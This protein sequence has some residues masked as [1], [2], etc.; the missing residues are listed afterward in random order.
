METDF[1]LALAREEERVAK[2]TSFAILDTPDEQE[3]DTI[4]QLAQTMLG[5]PI[6]VVSLVDRHRQWFKAKCGLSDSETSRDVAFCAH[7]IHYDDIMVVEDATLD[8]R[9]VANPLVTGDPGIRF[10]AGAPLRP[11]SHGHADDLPA[12]GTLCVIDVKPRTFSEEQVQTLRKLAGLVSSLVHARASAATALKLSEET[13]RRADAIA[14][15]HVQ[16]RQAE[17][18]AG[19][20]SWRLDLNDRS[21]FWSD[22]VY[23]IHGLPT[24]QMPSVDQAL[25]FYPE[26]RRGEIAALVERARTHGESFDFESDF[27]TADGRKR[28]VRSMGEVQFIDGAPV[29]LIGVFQDVT[30]H[31]LR[32]LTLRHT[33]DTDALTGLPNRA[34]FERRLAE[35][36][37]RAQAA[38]EPA[39]VLLL[40]LD[41]FKGVNDTFGHDAGDE[42]LRLMADRLCELAYSSSFAARLGGDE[43]V[44]LVTRPRDCANIENVIASI[45]G[46][47]RHSVERDGERRKVSATVGAAFVEPD[48]DAPTEAMRRADLALYAA[49]RVER[50]TGRVF[51]SPKVLRALQARIA[52]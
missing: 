4:V 8:S 17:R 42:V 32:E 2:L 12:I 41:G 15:Q 38:A 37:A 30:R 46:T 1:H 26:D 25:S 6:A 5:M 16:L 21:V 51:G 52:A 33:A 29:A 43:F 9:F 49:K 45:L 11:K 48:I 23:A 28:R 13:R 14:R 27:T 47:L 50:G 31:H 7:A 22:Q 18:M 44:M 24:G 10:Y 34:C 35:A 19:I 3:F 40:D 39:C 36:V 20:G